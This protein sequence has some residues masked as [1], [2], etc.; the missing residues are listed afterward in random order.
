MEAIGAQAEKRAL[1]VLRESP[2]DARLHAAL[3]RWVDLDCRRHGAFD[4]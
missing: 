1:A 3:T 2:A 4:G